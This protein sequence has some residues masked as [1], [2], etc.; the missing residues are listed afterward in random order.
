[1]SPPSR[2]SNAR[3]DDLGDWPIN[4]RRIGIW[5]MTGLHSSA[6]LNPTPDVECETRMVLTGRRRVTRSTG[7]R[8]VPATW[9]TYCDAGRMVLRGLTVRS[10]ISVAA[11]FGTWYTMLNQGGRI[12]HGD[13]PWLQI[14]LNYA[15]PFCVSS[16]G[17]LA[18]RRRRN[19]EYLVALLGDP[20]ANP[21][22]RRAS[23]RV[24]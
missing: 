17:F 7:R 21:S 20:A 8:P 19:V 6:R 2:T 23:R 11:V 16:L 9:V 13:F 22:G 15:T 5:E 4:R 3:T 12:A 24:P 14:V 18:G 1:M 10:G